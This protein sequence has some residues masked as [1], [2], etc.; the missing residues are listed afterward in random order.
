MAMHMND[1]G[2]KTKLGYNLVAAY[3][4]FDKD[5]FDETAKRWR[6][7]RTG[8]KC[9]KNESYFLVRI[10][11]R[12]YTWDLVYDTAEAANA[13]VKSLFD[14]HDSHKRTF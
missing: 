7:R 12:R 2:L 5:Y 3:D 9:Y 14:G 1:W 11:A 4:L 6:Y 10:C 13:K 8:V